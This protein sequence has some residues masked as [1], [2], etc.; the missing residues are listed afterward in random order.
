MP[1]AHRAAL[2]LLARGARIR[3]R[4]RRWR[5][6][7]GRIEEVT[8]ARGRPG[9][10]SPPPPPPERRGS[11]PPPPRPRLKPVIGHG[12]SAPYS[13]SPPLPPNHSPPP[14]SPTPNRSAP[15]GGRGRDDR[16][17]ADIVRFSPAL[18]RGLPMPSRRPP[19]T[20]PKGGQGSPL[21]ANPQREPRPPASTP[22][23]G[24]AP[25][26]EPRA[27]GVDAAPEPGRFLI[28]PPR[29][30][31]RL[32]P[33]PALAGPMAARAR[34]GQGGLASLRAAFLSP[35][36][37]SWGAPTP[38]P[39]S[40]EGRGC[41]YPPTPFPHRKGAPNHHG[42][43]GAPPF[44]APALCCG[45]T[46]APG[47]SPYAPCGPHVGPGGAADGLRRRP[48]RG[49]FSRLRRK[50]SPPGDGDF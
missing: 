29:P 28:N 32:A 43:A 23:T 16:K 38:L 33:P 39:P 13:S 24:V 8:V 42:G 49:L 41:P 46:R 21:L 26:V 50:T 34:E 20:H 31:P 22:P 40:R 44:A 6:G 37:L 14:F 7:R 36:V 30:R 4:A 18:P 15:V 11:Q 19:P 10:P 3:K 1:G 5:R 27:A 12:Q 45:P 48:F 25:A 17:G 47:A 9:P 2:P 35:P